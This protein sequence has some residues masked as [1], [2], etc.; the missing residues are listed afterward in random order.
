[1]VME[2]TPHV[3]L[4]GKGA[5]DFAAQQGVE[6]LPAEKL[7]TEAARAEWVQM[8][9]YRTAVNT[10]F[11]G[12]DGAAGEKI[13]DAA[14]SGHPPWTALCLVQAGVGRWHRLLVASR[15]ASRSL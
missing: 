12:T 8:A 5:T 14:G 10:L 13:P 6:I 11:N 9:A 15:F 3:L 7:V 1:M 4:V 2:R